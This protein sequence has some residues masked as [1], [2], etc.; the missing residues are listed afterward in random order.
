MI[1]DDIRALSAELARRRPSSD[2]WS[3]V[4]Y[5]GHL[6]E[7]MAFHRG[8]IESALAEDNPF[9]PM[10]DPDKSVAKAGYA[11]AD[12]GALVGQFERRVDRLCHLLAELDGGA[13]NRTL[14]LDDRQVTVGLVARSAWHECHHHRG[15]IRRLGRAS[16]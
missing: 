7:S 16:P 2:V 5:L 8:L 1:G 6:R 13:V 11:D 12:I 4:E 3:P 9:I 14:T 10:V 15:D